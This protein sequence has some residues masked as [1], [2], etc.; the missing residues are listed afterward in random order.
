[1]VAARSGLVADR[2]GTPAGWD[3]RSGTETRLIV[4]M[5]F[6]CLGASERDESKDKCDC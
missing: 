2:L 3:P 4:G 1:M 5:E 6:L